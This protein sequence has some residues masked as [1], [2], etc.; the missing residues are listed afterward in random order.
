VQFAQVSQLVVAG[1]GI[2][3]YREVI[4]LVD[5][6]TLKAM[7]RDNLLGVRPFSL[8]AQVGRRLQD[9]SPDNLMASYLVNLSFLCHLC[10]SS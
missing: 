4:E 9:L 2:A 7:T 3:A 6:V 1:D 10:C 8:L 5:P